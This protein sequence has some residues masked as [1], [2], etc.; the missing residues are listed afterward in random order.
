MVEVTKTI[1]CKTKKI[2]RYETSSRSKTPDFILIVD[3]LNF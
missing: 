2:E 1:N 3:I